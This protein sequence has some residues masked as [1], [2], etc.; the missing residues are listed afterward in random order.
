MEQELEE[1]SEEWRAA[2]EGPPPPPRQMVPG[3]VGD[4]NVRKAGCRGQTGTDS[5]WMWWEKK[6]S[7]HSAAPSQSWCLPRKRRSCLLPTEPEENTGQ[8][9]KKLKQDLG[10]H[11]RAGSL[12]SSVATGAAHLLLGSWGH[13]LPAGGKWLGERGY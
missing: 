11:L 9:P 2:L 13:G 8:W 10:N 1:G 4:V 3:E 6:G 5:G 12:R 7:E